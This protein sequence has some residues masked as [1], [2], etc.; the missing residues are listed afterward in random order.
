MPNPMTVEN[1]IHLLMQQVQRD[2]KLAYDLAAYRRGTDRRTS[3]Y[4]Y[5]SQVMDG[6][7][8]FWPTIVGDLDG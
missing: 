7:R 6:M 4:H 2:V 5:Y 8:D 1:T 3:R